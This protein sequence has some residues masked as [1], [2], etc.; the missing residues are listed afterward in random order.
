MI[1]YPS[2][3]RSHLAKDSNP[4]IAYL[5]HGS[6][7]AHVY[8]LKDTIINALLGPNENREYSLDRVEASDLTGNKS[9]I[10]S[11]VEAQSFFAENRVVYLQKATPQNNKAI[12]LALENWQQGYASLVV[13]APQ[14]TKSSELRKKF[15][16]EKNL[17][18]IGVYND[19]KQGNELRALIQESSLKSIS[20]DT[21]AF[22]EQ[23]V[24][25]HDPSMMKVWINTLALYKINDDTPLSVEDVQAC[26]P[27]TI[28]KGLEELIDIVA[29]RNRTQIS[30]IFRKLSP[31]DLNP[32]MICIRT[33]FKFRSL[34]SILSHPDGPHQGIRSLKPPVFG[35]R[36]ERLK[37]QVSKW[38]ITSA[39]KAMQILAE[40]DRRIRRPGVKPVESII[41]RS[42]LNLA[43]V[44]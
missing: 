17:A 38:N 3:L 8:Q 31:K 26:F 11:L 19:A 2:N 29:D 24:E 25:E 27:E 20:S 35:K 6:N 40:T 16:T 22:L 23:I 33:K 7:E 1:I 18:C 28:D 42:L 21:F 10:K 32:V 4:T 43:N 5:I 13:T 15:E 41:E 30:P 9:H 37:Q 36:G 44:K 39:T 14:L 34:L 12:F